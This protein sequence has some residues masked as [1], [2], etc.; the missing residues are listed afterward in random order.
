M[1]TLPDL[2]ER[3]RQYRIDFPEGMGSSLFR[4][5]PGTKISAGGASLG[6]F[7]VNPF[8]VPVHC[9]QHRMITW[10]FAILDPEFPTLVI[11]RSGEGMEFFT[12]N[13]FHGFPGQVRQE[14][15]AHQDPARSSRP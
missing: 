1:V 13:R 9:G 8:D 4:E 3:S 2:L 6:K 5:E 15:E 14:R 7:V 10:N 11:N 12:S